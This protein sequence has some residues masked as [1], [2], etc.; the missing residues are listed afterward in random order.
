[1]PK[2]FTLLLL[3]VTFQIGFAQDQGTVKCSEEASYSV[4]GVLT[5]DSDKFP[6]LEMTTDESLRPGDRGE[7]QKYFE[8]P[9]FRTVLT[10]WI[11]IGVVEVVSAKGKTV[12]FK[13]I[14]ET[15][16]ITING[17]KTNHFAKGKR[18]QFT[19]YEYGTPVID[20]TFW[21]NG[22]V[23]AVGTKICDVPSGEWKQFNDSGKLSEKYFLNDQGKKEG[24]YESYHENGK[25]KDRGNY[26]A[27]KQ[28]GEWFGFHENGK[29]SYIEIWSAGQLTGKS[30]SWYEN[31]QKKSE[32]FYGIDG[33]REGTWL[34]WHDNGNL[35][36]K[37]TYSSGALNGIHETYYTN[38]QLAE[39]YGVSL[40]A[41]KMA[42]YRV[43]SKAILSTS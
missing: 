18:V 34:E 4:E 29:S 1:M 9:F 8:T 5:T 15:S 10:G 35:M 42:F 38:G 20:S 2:T 25:L 33:K 30:A 13:V 12:K 40:S 19:K 41:V 36:E 21:S 28:T 39:R 16:T 11:G 23:R 27:N 6:V 26:A 17:E 43:R 24:V 22:K 37:N 14:E 7:M 3:L 31:G 32:G